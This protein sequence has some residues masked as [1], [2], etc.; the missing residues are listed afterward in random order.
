MVFKFTELNSALSYTDVNH[1][2][3]SD[4]VTSDVHVTESKLWVTVYKQL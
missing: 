4:G 3:D 2:I 1:V